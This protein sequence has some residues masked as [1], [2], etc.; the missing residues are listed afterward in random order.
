MVLEL[1]GRPVDI[2]GRWRRLRERAAGVGDFTP[3]VSPVSH[4][5]TMHTGPLG[6]TVHVLHADAATVAALASVDWSRHFP[7][8]CLDPVRGLITL[9]SPSFPH[10][11]LATVLE[12]IVDIAGSAFGGCVQGAPQH[13]APRAGRA[14]RHGDGARLRVLHR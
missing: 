7:R 12:D 11:D 14:A 8:V 6:S 10:D 5:T 1:R 9:M 4:P 13:P 3:E 2:R